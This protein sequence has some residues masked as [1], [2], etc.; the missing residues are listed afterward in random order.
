[1]NR[2]NKP[3]KG[4]TVYREQ[5]TALTNELPNL[6]I[7]QFN[8]LSAN[9][10]SKMTGTGISPEAIQTILTGFGSPKRKIRNSSVETITAALFSTAIS[11]CSADPNKTSE[12]V[13]AECL[14]LA[15][16]YYSDCTTDEI[17]EA[18]RMAGAGKYPEIDFAAYRGQFSATIF[19]KVMNRYV[20]DRNRIKSVVDG[21]LEA[22]NDEKRQQITTEKNAA[23]AVET[24][25]KFDA[26]KESISKGIAKAPEIEQIPLY[27][28]DAVYPAGRLNFP[29][30][31]KALLWEKA[32]EMTKADLSRARSTAGQYARGGFDAMLQAIERNQENGDVQAKRENFYKKLLLYRALTQ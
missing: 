24:L 19:C 26:L 11:Y 10:R 6:S 2:N 5:I 15:G 29:R 17:L 32:L 9:V 28:F 23:A 14:E 18:F 12:L 27:W 1:M 30:E 13:W 8:E 22:L 25:K 31:E 21:F 20:E 4:V 7:G 16:R 3:T